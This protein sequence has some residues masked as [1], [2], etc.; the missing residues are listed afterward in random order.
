MPGLRLP[1]RVDGDSGMGSHGVAGGMMRVQHDLVIFGVLMMAAGGFGAA[2]SAV[3]YR[4]AAE[5]VIEIT[6]SPQSSFGRTLTVQPDGK[7][8]YPIAGQ[9]EVVGLTV[10]QL[11][12][13]LQEALN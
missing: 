2:A 6:V 8:S 7:I 10:E 1:F 4:F 12:K 9:V 5:D 11:A 13:K 3:D